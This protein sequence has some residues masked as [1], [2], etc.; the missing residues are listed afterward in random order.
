MET[1]CDWE[2]HTGPTSQVISHGP[3]RINP[4]SH[5]IRATPPYVVP[6]GVFAVPFVGD[7]SPQSRKENI[8]IIEN[9]TS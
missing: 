7:G 6:F 9:N 5:N 8:I 2:L 1:H 3:S 4:S